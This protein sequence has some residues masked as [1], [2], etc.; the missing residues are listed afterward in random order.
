MQTSTHSSA[1]SLPTVPR[2]L[3][4]FLLGMP[5]GFADS[6]KEPSIS[7]PAIYGAWQIPMALLVGA[8]LVS[9]LLDPQVRRGGVR[10]GRVL[11]RVAW[12]LLFAGMV[13]AGE[14]ALLQVIQATTRLDLYLI[15]LVIGPLLVALA[16]A[17]TVGSRG[18]W[19]LALA[20]GLAGWLGAG[21]QVVAIALI[22]SIVYERRLHGTTYELLSTI[23]YAVACF[24][25]AALG[26][27]LGR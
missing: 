8:A 19:P 10:P 20:I 2:L 12:V 17:F 4:A 16:V 3:I 22:D 24:P 26:G 6:L 1:S 18:S 9:L 23:V 14:I 5:F 27:V 21:L 15:N 13:I 25:L 7:A 11:V